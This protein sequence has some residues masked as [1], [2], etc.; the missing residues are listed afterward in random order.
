M[1]PVSCQPQQQH[2]GEHGEVHDDA[3]AAHQA[4]LART[5]AA[6]TRPPV[7]AG[8][9]AAPPVVAGHRDWQVAPPRAVVGA[10]RLRRSGRRQAGHVAGAS[11][12]SGRQDARPSRRSS[13]A[14]RPRAKT[15]SA[16]RA[17]QRSLTPSPNTMTTSPGRRSGAQDARLAAARP[18]A[19][20]VA[21][22]RVEADVVG[23]PVRPGPS[24]TSSLARTLDRAPAPRAARR[25]RWPRESRR[26]PPPPDRRRRPPAPQ[27]SRRPGCG[28]AAAASRRRGSSAR[29]ART[30]RDLAVEALGVAHAP[31]RGPRPRSARQAS[32]TS[33]CSAISLY[34]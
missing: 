6:A 9:A 7:G 8:V 16:S 17:G 19:R 4:E 2:A 14:S 24:L 15:M 30:R 1:W 23:G 12:S 31:R 3:G 10:S 28:W 32:P 21:E 25:P 22:L 20:A 29:G 27:E 33:C 34:S 5:A 18:A 13:S 11:K 26:W